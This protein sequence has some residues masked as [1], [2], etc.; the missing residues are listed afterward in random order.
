MFIVYAVLAGLALGALAGGR[1][2]RLGTVELRWLPAIALALAIQV[3][4]FG[5]LGEMFGPRDPL[6][7]AIYVATSLVALGAVVANLARPG[8]VLVALGGAANLAAIVANGGVMPASPD[9]LAALG[10]S[11]GADSF[12]NSAV[13]DAPALPWLTDVFAMPAGLPFANVFS[14]GDVLI[15]LGIALFLSRSMVTPRPSHRAG[16]PL[17]G[18]A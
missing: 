9:A 6:P 5:P 1:L 14:V 4:L 2:E 10:W 11:T 17:G 18:G 3:P 12:S 13:V 8:F 7:V 15:G 16:P